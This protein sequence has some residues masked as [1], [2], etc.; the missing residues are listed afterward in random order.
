MLGNQ[1]IQL[2]KDKG[3]T[4]ETLAGI[5]GVTMQAVSKWENDTCCPDMGLLIPLADYF[6][7]TIDYLFGRSVAYASVLDLPTDSKL[8]IIQYRNGRVLRQNEWDKNV[9]IKLPIAAEDIPGRTISLEVWG[10]VAVEG[11]ICGNVNAGAQVKC[12]NIEGK[13]NAG[14]QVN[15]GNI[16]G[17]ANAGGQVNCGDVGGDACAGGAINC[18]CIEGNVQAGGAVKCDEINGDVRCEAD[19]ECNEINGK[20]ECKGSIYYRS[21]N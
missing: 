12:G 19:I 8:R 3:I 2:R 1:I 6:G 14:G 16:E 9:N 17:G 20:V 15:C 21:K 10:N 5:L 4:Q 7:V 11:D 18:G 13:V